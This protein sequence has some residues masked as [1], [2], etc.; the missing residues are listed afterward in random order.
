MAHNLWA[1]SYKI[2]EK[3]SG[4]I[5]FLTYFNHVKPSFIKEIVQTLNIRNDILAEIKPQ[6]A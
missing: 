6:N 4:L 3:S 1:I 5:S 2:H